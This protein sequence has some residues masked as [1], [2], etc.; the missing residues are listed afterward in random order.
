MKK[1]IILLSVIFLLINIGCLN[2]SEK[3]NELINQANI[4]IDKSV[5][6]ENNQIA[7]LGKEINR[8]PAT[9]KGALKSRQNSK[10]ILKKVD[11]QFNLLKKAKQ[12]IES[13][14][15]LSVSSE[16]IKYSNLTIK[17]L[18][19]DIES[20]ETTKNLYIQ[21][22]KMYELAAEN[23]LTQLQYQ[24]ISNKVDT[25]TGKAAKIAQE[26][27][28]LHRKKDIYYQKSQLAK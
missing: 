13:I 10:E 26:Q 2:D 7:P 11:M 9:Q 20:L 4:A 8:T 6:V 28:T 24:K 16:F 1:I 25:L 22:K 3:A 18:D 23:R 21:L 27:H 14:K 15:R 5:Q 19:A 12:D 17:A